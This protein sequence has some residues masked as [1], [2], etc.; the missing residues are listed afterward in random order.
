[1][2]IAGKEQKLNWS[3]ATHW[4]FTISGVKA[5]ELTLEFLDYDKKPIGKSSVQVN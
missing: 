3:D 4:K 1:V 5:G 2:R